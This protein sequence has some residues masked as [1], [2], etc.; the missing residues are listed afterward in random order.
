MKSLSICITTFN[1]KLTIKD[2]LKSTINQIVG[3]DQIIIIDD[4]SQDET[5]KIAEDFLKKNKQE[6]T[7]YIFPKNNGGPACS[8]N[9]GIEL[10]SCD[11]V[12]FLDGDDINLSNRCLEIKN[13]IKEDNHNILIHSGFAAQIK[14]RKIYNISKLN[15]LE[16]KNTSLKNLLKTDQLSPGSS[17][18][19][20]NTKDK[21]YRFNDSEDLIAGEDR[22]LCLNIAAK[23]GAIKS[24]QE[25]L[26][27]YNNQNLYNKSQKNIQHITSP[28]KTIKIINYFKLNYC[29]K[30]EYFFSNLELSLIIAHIRTKNHKKALDIFRKLSTLQ[31]I[32]IMKTLIGKS[33]SSYILIKYINF[34]NRKVYK[35]YISKYLKL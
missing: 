24:T 11:Y 15:T 9:K 7:L 34:R 26:F 27:I 19:I 21:F 10:S 14:N 29:F 3:F 31:K 32:A 23:N 4:K 12:C 13:I 17:I 30:F 35:E 16:N 33:Y 22:E 25:K 18:V 20:K 2:A 1:N 8:R 5:I 6:Y 28:N